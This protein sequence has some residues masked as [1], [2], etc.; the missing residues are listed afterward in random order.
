[1]IL[2]KDPVNQEDFDI[3]ISQG[4]SV[5]L[6]IMANGMWFADPK[7]LLFS[8]ARYKFV[9]KMF[10]GRKLAVEIG[11]SDAFFAPI[12]AQSVEKLTVTDFDP[13]FIDQADKQKK[14]LNPKWHYNSFVHDI[15]KAPLPGTYDVA[16]SLDV[17]EHIPK[18]KEDIYLQ[19]IISALHETGE[20]IIGMPSLESQAYA[21]PSSK[22][23]H[24]N[25]KSGL[26]LKKT[27]EKYFHS[28]FL[29]SIN[30]EV[31]HTGFNKLAH[32]NLVLCAHL[33]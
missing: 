28:V 1:M 25:C 3:L 13:A 4:G 30:D 29:F 2:A 32:Y 19:N 31:V 5:S 17:M 10:E 11:C 24:V 26:D 15:L 18:E 14:R 7:K 21:S 23:G 22:I 8:L 27:V 16:F 6:G 33:K 12:V 9:A 20:L